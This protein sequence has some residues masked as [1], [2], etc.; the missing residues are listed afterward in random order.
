MQSLANHGELSRN[1]NHLPK[2]SM[3]TLIIDDNK[4]DGIKLAVTN[5]E[6]NL[7]LMNVEWPPPLLLFPYKKA[8]VR[9]FWMLNTP[10]PL[11][12]IFCN[13]NRVIYVGRGE[14]FNSEDLIGPNENCTLVLEAPNGFVDY[15]DIKVGSKV[16]VRYNPEELAN[17]LKN[18]S[19][20]VNAE[21]NGK[22]DHSK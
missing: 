11:D 10:S 4:F 16:R 5:E 1:Q 12:I 6:Q 17:I 19:P 7:G 21:N 18:G 13:A 22:N 15:H 2:G 14:P 20:K 9:K 3:A 8:G